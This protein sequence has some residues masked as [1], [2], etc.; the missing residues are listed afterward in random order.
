MEAKI[1]AEKD[2]KELT[3][4]EHKRIRDQEKEG[5]KEKKEDRTKKK[6]GDGETATAAPAAAAAES[7][8]MTERQREA[9]KLEEEKKEKEKQRREELKRAEFHDQEKELQ[10]RLFRSQNKVRY[11]PLPVH[12][13][14]INFYYALGRD[15]SRI[16]ILELRFYRIWDLIKNVLFT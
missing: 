9:A 7:V 3:A 14:S 6:V 5:K 12:H 13:E 4:Q 1:E 11:L 16:R 15:G 2:L 10:E 8:T